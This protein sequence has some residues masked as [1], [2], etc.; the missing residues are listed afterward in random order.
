MTSG[1]VA[2]VFVDANVLYSRTLRDWLALLYLNPGNEMFEVLWSDDVMA[3]FHYHFRKNHPLL[4][5][6]QVGGIRR[7]LEN[8]FKTGRVTGYTIDRAVTYP[9]PGDAH[10]HC[11][12]VHCNADILLTN[13]GK[14]FTQLGDVPYEIYTADEF[15]EH[16]DTAMPHVVREVVGE[17]LVYHLTRGGD[18]SV[19]LPDKLKSAQAPLFAERVRRHLQT[20]D[21]NALLGRTFTAPTAGPHL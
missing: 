20:L 11:A 21:V 7:R 19:G 4:D 10:V 15:F 2:S 1:W 5:D 6:A 3:E 17:Q 14:D 12:A 8:S 16:V 13:N 9:D 18:R